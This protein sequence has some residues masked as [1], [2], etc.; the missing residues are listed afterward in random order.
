MHI[1]GN[2]LI[3][4][5]GLIGGNRLVRGKGPIKSKGYIGVKGLRAWPLLH[6]PAPIS[7]TA[8]IGSESVLR[9][10]IAGATVV[11]RH[12]SWA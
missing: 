10:A 9:T 3:Q 1:R 2:R 5:K 4:G 11:Y 8:T 7:S 12:H 6:T